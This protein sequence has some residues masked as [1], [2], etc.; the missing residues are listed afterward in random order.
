M[1]RLYSQDKGDKKNQN[2]KK[3]RLSKLV[4][5]LYNTLLSCSNR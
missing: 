2:Y 1:T 4:Q 5:K 3:N